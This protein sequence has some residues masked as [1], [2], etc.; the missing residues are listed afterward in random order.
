MLLYS[1]TKFL[2]L[3]PQNQ[4]HEGE[5]DEKDS[6]TLYPGNNPYEPYREAT[7]LT[8][9]GSWAKSSAR[10]ELDGDL[11]ILVENVAEHDLNYRSRTVQS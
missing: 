9:L 5:K 2:I 6:R 4:I 11:L 3:S 7:N 8:N 10:P 1:Y